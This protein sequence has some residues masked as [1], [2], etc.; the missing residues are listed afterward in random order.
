[1]SEDRCRHCRYCETVL[2]PCM[3]ISVQMSHKYFVDFIT[4]GNE[5][6]AEEIFSD[7]CVHLDV[8]WD[9]AHPSVGTKALKQ[10]LHDLKTTFPDF[11]VDIDEIATCDA[12]GS[13]WVS[14][15]GN[16]TGLGEWKHQLK[17]S[18]HSSHFTGVNLFKFNDDR[19]KIVE[20]RVYRSA[21]AED[22]EEIKEMVPG[23]NFRELR[24]RRLA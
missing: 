12:N 1:V 24:L 8:V 10:Y 14:Y 18:H 13:L 4:Q 15:E 11:Q 21:F 23:G 19:T 17:A 20:V 5:N 3:H 7:E 22:K 16:A 2:K 6:I 9:P